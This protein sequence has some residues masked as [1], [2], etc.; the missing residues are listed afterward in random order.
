MREH[1]A[2][3]GSHLTASEIS[4]HEPRTRRIRALDVLRNDDKDCAS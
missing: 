1:L 4:M 3:I 2:L